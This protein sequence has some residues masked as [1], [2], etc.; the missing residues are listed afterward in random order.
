MDTSKRKDADTPVR[1]TIVL[2]RDLWR[3]VKVRAI[4]DGDLNTVVINALK[5]YLRGAKK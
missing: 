2:P 1:T 5:L 4:E 3:Q